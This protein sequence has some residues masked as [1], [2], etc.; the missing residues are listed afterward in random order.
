MI[1]LGACSQTIL[2]IN[3]IAVWE[4][5]PDNYENNIDYDIWRLFQTIVN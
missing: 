3:I 4:Q 5:A 2:N 1:T